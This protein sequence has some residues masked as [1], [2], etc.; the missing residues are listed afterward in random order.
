MK[1]DPTVW[2]ASTASANL[3]LPVLKQTSY[4]VDRRVLRSILLGP[5]IAPHVTYDAAVVSYTLH[6]DSVEAHLANGR[7]IHGSLLVGADGIRSHVASQLLRRPSE[8]TGDDKQSAS[9]TID[10]N[11]RCLYGKAPL[12]SKL[13]EKLQADL[14]ERMAFVVDSTFLPPSERIMIVVVPMRF[15]RSIS[16]EDKAAVGME[17][18]NVP[19]DYVFFAMVGRKEIWHTAMRSSSTTKSSSSADDEQLDQELV[20]MTGTACKELSIDMARQRGWHPSTLALLEMQDDKETAVLKI[21]SSDTSGP[22]VW[23]RSD[24]VTVL[25]D[26]IH[27]MPPTGGN[28]A[29]TA[30]WDAA[31]LGKLLAEEMAARADTAVEVQGQ[32][33]PEG[34]KGEDWKWSTKTIRRYEDAMRKNAGDIVGLACI[35]ATYLFGGEEVWR[36]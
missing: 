3:D 25:G 10:L 30:L 29:N 18:V 15:D 31:V 24:R 22:P 11:V 34:E 8:P 21:R 26:A 12:T 5:E 28:G 36:S 6:P 32:R 4:Q 20:R 17:S 16:A 23:E 19:E 9:K 13:L 35:G 2:A 1:T 14:H 7:S 33:G 27:C